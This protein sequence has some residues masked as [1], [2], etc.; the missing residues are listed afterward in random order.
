MWIKERT[1]YESQ[2]FASPPSEITGQLEIIADWNGA[3][4]LNVL[5]YLNQ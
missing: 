2:K 3:K 5:N 1:P 4:R